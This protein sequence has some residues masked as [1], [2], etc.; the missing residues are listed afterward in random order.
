MTDR[1]EKPVVQ[2]SASSPVAETPRVQ[3]RASWGTRVFE[4]FV[5]RDALAAA[6]MRC[7]AYLAGQPACFAHAA[8]AFGAAERLIA[9][10]REPGAETPDEP[11]SRALALS[12]L[13]EAAF[14]ALCAMS[15]GVERTD[16]ATA[17]RT[18]PTA[19]VTDAVG[20]EEIVTRA[21][22]ALA[23]RTFQDTADLDASLLQDDL[24]SA[25][26]FVSGL[27]AALDPRTRRVPVLLRERYTRLVGAVVLVAALGV[28]TAWLT[29]VLGRNLAESAPWR[30]SSASGELPGTGVGFHP[31]EGRFNIF[32]NTREEASPWI[33]FDLGAVRGVSYLSVNNRMDC[34]QERAAPLV[35]E[36]STDRA[37]WTE[38][39]RQT[40]RFYYWREWFRSH[41]A[42]FV[43]LR[44]LRATQLH[45]GSV[46]VN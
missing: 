34:C 21:R 33:E 2:P 15:A 38:V 46:F 1:P 40:E 41:P 8:A 10:G 32:F 42:R 3:V 37:H 11:E 45:L 25:R 13:R 31:P 22:A 35:F 23:E 14:W 4:W 19:L 24:A 5:R 7:D 39:V 26:G 16:L 30:T 27:L 18:V 28:V 6:H 9:Y 44:V 29:H 43:R 12:L 20:G 36:V 17:L